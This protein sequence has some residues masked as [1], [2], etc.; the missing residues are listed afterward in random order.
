[1]SSSRSH[2]YYTVFIEFPDG[3]LRLA[4]LPTCSSALPVLAERD[5]FPF[6]PDEAIARPLARAPLI[7]TLAKPPNTCS[8][9]RKWAWSKTKGR[10]RDRTTNI[11]AEPRI[12]SW[13]R[14]YVLS[15]SQVNTRRRR[16]RSANPRTPSPFHSNACMPA[17]PAD[18]GGRKKGRGEGLQPLST[19]GPHPGG[20]GYYIF[21][22]LDAAN[23]QARS[24]AS[25]P[26]SLSWSHPISYSRSLIPYPHLITFPPHSLPTPTS[27]PHPAPHPLPAPS[28]S[29]PRRLPSPPQPL[30]ALPTASHSAPSQSFPQAAAAA[31]RLT[32]TRE[33]RCG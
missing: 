8:W 17:T 7:Q 4:S 9:R 15:R 21:N 14:R 10:P 16:D 3:A 20:W 2:T 24:L 31:C 25:Y 6:P 22:V 1:M 19:S 11:P 13:L 12:S 33:C 29:P 23:P 26:L 28:P 5:P 30:P 27:Y 32:S 18:H